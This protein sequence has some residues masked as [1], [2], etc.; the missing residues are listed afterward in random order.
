MPEQQAESLPA[1]IPYELTYSPG[2]KASGVPINQQAGRLELQE[3]RTAVV[4][5]LSAEG[6]TDA[7]ERRTDRMVTGC[8]RLQSEPSLHPYR[9]E[10]DWLGGGFGYTNDFPSEQAAC[11]WGQAKAKHHPDAV[12]S[13]MTRRAA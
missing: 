4:E 6:A 9:V 3:R 12:V 5:A 8:T 11:A 10:A 1:L 13:V 7:F 2:H